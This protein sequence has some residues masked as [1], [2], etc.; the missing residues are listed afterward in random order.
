T[1]TPRPTPTPVTSPI[2][3]TLAG[4]VTFFYGDWETAISE[5]QQTLESSPSPQEKSAALLGLGK[6][7]YQLQNYP[8]ALDNLRTLLSSYSDS[9]TVAEAQFVLAQTYTALNRH[10]EAASAYEAYL[11]YNLGIIDAYIQEQRGDAYT[12]AGKY[13]IAIEAYQAAIAADSLQDNVNLRLKMGQ[14]YF[15]LEDYPTSIVLYEEAYAETNNDYLKASADYLLGLAFTALERP[16]QAQ[17]AYR[18]AVENYP[19]SYDA[20]LS[21]VELIEAGCHVSELDRGLVDYFAGQYGLASEAFDRYISQVK[22]GEITEGDPA[23]AYYYKGFALRAQGDAEGALWAWDKVIENYPEHAYWDNAWEYKAYTQWAYLNRYSHAVQTLTGFV[24]KRPYH[25]RAAE[26]LFDAARVEELTKDYDAAIS[27]WNHIISE[28]PTSDYANNALFLIG[29]THYRVEAYQQAT[30]VFTRY[31][32]AAQTPEELARA[33]FW[34]GKAHH[35]AGENL[36]AQSAWEN[37]VNID[38]TG[39]YSERAIDLLQGREAFISPLDYD[40]SYDVEAKRQ[41]AEDWM[42]SAFAIPPATNLS[43]LGMLAED[44]RLIRGTEFWNLG[45]YDKARLEFENLRNEVSYDPISS[46][47]LA[48]YLSELGLY[49]PAIFAARQ[50][51]NAAN[52]DDAATMNAPLY[53]NYIRFG[54][55]YRD[56]IIPVAQKYGFHPLFL[57][58]VVRQES[59]FEGFV[60]SSAGARGLMQIMPSTGEDLARKAGWPPNYTA[61]DLYRP[62][63]SVNLGTAYLDSQRRY[64]EGDIY[65]ALAAYNAGAGN[66]LTW[67]EVSNDDPD[68]FL[69]TIRFSETRRYIKGIK[70]IF[71]IYR[72]LYGREQ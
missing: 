49:R 36:S 30:G 37:A 4:D 62:K 46:Y 16:I 51:L 21:L 40:L 5:Y 68:L 55:Y 58:S 48:N 2:K 27:L 3:S 39:Y 24:D 14:A 1:V 53:F 63:V 19:L 61:E 32:A 47:R 52:M 60:R 18:D 9:S 8:E 41:E 70:E 50:V 13:L 43:G 35:S 11:S 12:A 28:Y 65:A 59:L 26:F 38:L 44:A 6:T 64:F 45:L 54:S 10:L 42:R 7:Y 25:E 72:R 56:L 31:V 69:E 15:A 29:I 67:S 66:A 17:A 71:A 20:Y 33:Y 57:F 22:T 23:T 34:L